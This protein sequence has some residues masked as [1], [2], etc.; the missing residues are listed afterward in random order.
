MKIIKKNT[1]VQDRSFT[2]PRYSLIGPDLSAGKEKR[3]LLFISR[4]RC[5]G[6]DLSALR[7]TAW[8]SHKNGSCL[9]ML[10]KKYDGTLSFFPR[11]LGSLPDR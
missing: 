1:S 9:G 4:V 3:K 6:D 8:A 11:M 10:R 5:L 2:G 7:Q